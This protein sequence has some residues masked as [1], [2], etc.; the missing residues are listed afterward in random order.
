MTTDILK[1]FVLSLTGFYHINREV[2]LIYQ[3]TAITLCIE[4]IKQI[5]SL[6]ATAN[7]FTQVEFQLN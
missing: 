5:F 2:N 7:F 6:V 3:V 4:N 1:T